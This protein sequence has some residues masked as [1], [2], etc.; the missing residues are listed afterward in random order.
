[1][2][3]AKTIEELRALAAK[4]HPDRPGGSHDAMSE[5]NQAR[6]EGLKENGHDRH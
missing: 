6:D 2:I 3:D 4:R 5:I 1:M